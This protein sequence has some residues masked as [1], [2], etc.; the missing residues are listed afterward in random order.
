MLLCRCMKSVIPVHW[1][2]LY[3]FRGPQILPVTPSNV[4]FPT[5]PSN[6][7]FCQPAF[8]VSSSAFFSNFWN[9]PGLTSSG[10]LVSH[11]QLRNSTRFSRSAASD[12]RES[13]VTAT[14]PT[15]FIKTS[16]LRWESTKKGIIN[17]EQ[18]VSR[19]FKNTWNNEESWH[20]NNNQ[21]QNM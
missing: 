6:P 16:L 15:A 21:D 7:V 20:W 14:K 8:S 4:H 9:W 18:F 13:L 3:P 1:Q 10:R 11:T 12:Y 2:L 5:Q 19:D 17:R